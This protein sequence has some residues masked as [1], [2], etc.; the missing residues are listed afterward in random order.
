MVTSE[1][2]D[3]CELALK[4]YINSS[5]TM[6]QIASKYK[7]A[8]SFISGYMLAKGVDIY[9]KK[10]SVNNYIFETI[11]TEEKAYWLGFLYADGN[12]RISN[13]S[14]KVELALKESDLEH[15]IKFSNFMDLKKHPKYIL[16]QKAY[17][18]FFGSRKVVEDLINKG[19]VTKKSLILE[20][21]NYEVVSKEMMPAFIR[22][23]FDGDGSI[24][25]TKTKLTYRANI[26]II[27]TKEFLTGLLN[28]LNIVEVPILKKDKRHLNNTFYV[29]FR[30]QQ[31]IEFLNYIYYNANIYLDRKY[32]NYKLAVP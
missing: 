7:I 10:S 27:G 26:S 6:R 5:M 25:L 22:G 18:V 31:G 15:L 23:Y 8:R 24:S 1:V 4:E 9:S 19:C 3:R 16:K 21:P 29:Q 13:N 2:I 20:F 32:S 28:E 11:D 30:K 12:V 17:K 14:Y